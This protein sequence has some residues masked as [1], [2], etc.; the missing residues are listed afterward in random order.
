ML[1][2]RA[3]ARKARLSRNRKAGSTL[4]RSGTTG[5]GALRD[6]GD[7]EMQHPLH[8]SLHTVFTAGLTGPS[9]QPWTQPCRRRAQWASATTTWNST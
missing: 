7:I 6:T 2:G 8:T 3:F 4:H 5:W 1:Q 9:M